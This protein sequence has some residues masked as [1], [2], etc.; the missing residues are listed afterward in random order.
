M[1]EGKIWK[2]LSWPGTCPRA[3][4]QQKEV[5]D[6]D[7]TSDGSSQQRATTKRCR[8]IL[9]KPLFKSG[10]YLAAVKHFTEMTLQI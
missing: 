3:G 10:Q 2:D 8:F 6:G 5:Y 1:D 4:L 9:N 7:L